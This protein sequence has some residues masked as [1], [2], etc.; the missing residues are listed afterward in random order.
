MTTVFNPGN[1]DL[2]NVDGFLVEADALHVAE[3]IKEYDPNLEI[4]CLKPE[5]A[6]FGDAPYQICHK[7]SNGVLRKIFDCWELDERVLSRIQLADGQRQNVIDV[8]DGMEAAIKKN[9]DDRYNDFREARKDLVAHIAG[10]RRSVY[11]FRDDTTGQLVKIYDD[12]PSER[13]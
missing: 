7:D 10:N 12:R 6:G 8:L 13:K 4:L 9:D 3:K 5:M 11:S 2:I 1:N